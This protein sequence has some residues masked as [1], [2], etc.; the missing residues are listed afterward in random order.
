MRGAH[1]VPVATQNAV[2]NASRI[3]IE[4]TNRSMP[5]SHSS[6]AFPLTQ[7]S[8]ISKGLSWGE[9]NLDERP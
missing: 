6:D 4:Q 7:N 9:K 3:F 1:A 2:T 8:S 5:T